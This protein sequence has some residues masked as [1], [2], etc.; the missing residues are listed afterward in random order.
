M[1]DGQHTI[2]VSR[3]CRA[4]AVDAV[5]QLHVTVHN[6]YAWCWKG[7]EHMC[8]MSSTRTEKNHNHAVA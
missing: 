8:V 6:T 3:F 7:D 5:L 4:C 2:L 1:R